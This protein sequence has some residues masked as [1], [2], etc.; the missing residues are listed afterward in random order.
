MTFSEGDQ[1]F[2]G[3]FHA[4]LDEVKADLLQYTNKLNWEWIF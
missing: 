1:V 4:V 3:D 2:A